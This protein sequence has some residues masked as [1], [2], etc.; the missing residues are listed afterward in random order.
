MLLLAL[1]ETAN[2]HLLMLIVDETIRANIAI[3]IIQSA[4]RRAQP[5][6]QS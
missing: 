6:G 3:C 2:R 1:A 4:C 5:H